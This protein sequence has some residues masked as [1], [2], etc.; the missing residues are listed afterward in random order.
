MPRQVFQV[1]VITKVKVVNDAWQYRVKWAGYDSSEDTWEPEKNLIGCQRLT[2][3]FWAHFM[4]DG[5]RR[6]PEGTVIH[7]TPE[8]IEREKEIF[9]AD[10]KKEKAAKMKKAAAAKSKKASASTTTKKS[11]SK[12]S[13]SSRAKGKQ[14][15]RPVVE[16]S[17]SSDEPLA[18]KPR[19]SISGDENRSASVSSVRSNPN[20]ASASTSKTKR[21]VSARRQASPVPVEDHL[22]LF[23]PFPSPSESAPPPPKPFQ[24][25]PTQPKPARPAA[26][27]VTTSTSALT[28]QPIPS[29][30]LPP[31]AS[32]APKHFPKLPKPGPVLNKPQTA[33]PL[34]IKLPASPP[35]Q[36][37][38]A[39]GSS[40]TT[41][42]RLAE[43]ALS[44]LPPK[45]SRQD[46]PKFKKTITTTPDTSTKT[47]ITEA[48]KAS[49]AAVSAL[50]RSS[51]SEAQDARVATPPVTQDVQPSF[52]RKSSSP[53]PRQ[54][55]ASVFLPAVAEP[56][57]SHSP[58]TSY[59]PETGDIVAS[60]IDCFDDPM[61]IDSSF[62][63]HVGTMSSVVESS[64]SADMLAAE[65]FLHGLMPPG[66]AAP[67]EPADAALTPTTFGPPAV[68]LGRGKLPPLPK[69]S[70]VYKWH[71][72]LYTSDGQTKTCDVSLVDVSEAPAEGCRF[73]PFLDNI[74]TIRSSTFYDLVDLD[75]FLLACDKPHQIGRLTG[76]E[77]ADLE[78]MNP[79]TEYMGRFKKAIIYP[80]ALDDEVMAYMVM[81]SPKTGSLSKR[82]RIPAN[83]LNHSASLI[84]ALVP[85]KDILRYHKDEWRHR[86]DNYPLRDYK[87]P[88]MDKTRL[89]RSLRSNPDFLL[90]LHALKF[91]QD[92]WDF[93]VKDRRDY[94]IWHEGGDGIGKNYGAQTHHLIKIL[95]EC[96]ARNKG[97]KADVRI[98]FVHVGALRTLPQ[99]IALAERR[100][101]RPE[102]NFFTY[103]SHESVEF[104]RWGVRH[105]YPLGGLV[106]FTPR[107]ILGDNDPLL[108]MKRIQHI[109]R[110]GHW[111][112]Y[113]LPSVVAYAAKLATAPDDP[114]MAFDEGTLRSSF[115]FDF[116]E[117]G[118][119]AMNEAP[120]S[121]LQLMLA[122]RGDLIADLL[123]QTDWEK[124]DY[125]VEAMKRFDAL[126]GPIPEQ[127]R[128]DAIK[129]EVVKSITA[130]QLQPGIMDNYR[131]FIII[132]APD[133]SGF[134]S[135][136]GLE[137]MTIDDFDFKDN[138]FPRQ[139]PNGAPVTPVI[140][141]FKPKNIRT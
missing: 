59:F 68:G 98:V 5:R 7:A 82:Y 119:V 37:S 79:L 104:D 89:D 97:Y 103:G 30:I 100:S 41:K 47:P 11:Q 76:Q 49:L 80:L 61:D 87:L 72:A 71:G 46:L 67:L 101:K 21:S 60:P 113:V 129:E 75:T 85:G 39:V 45:Q 84:V 56:S 23:T 58:V 44:L 20:A 22:A 13:S 83:M 107:A 105:I 114:L 62:N 6:H 4:C 48:A 42:Q 94:L 19:V 43:T 132:K 134:P 28:S 38:S 90:A 51:S 26:M 117:E 27:K 24:S 55:S 136:I 131:R 78:A 81:F 12:V 139:K 109:A 112:S 70:K 141:S 137:Y 35:K 10:E 111:A 127:A 18:Q 31:P 108:L 40:L 63:D 124:R 15:A 14:K 3:S 120:P 54:P 95:D 121:D 86:I 69:I 65:Q 77:A 135:D 17:S 116:I 133:E 9:W 140:E 16:T 53:A 73:K 66:L 125:L 25:E 122:Q 102:I 130:M 110:H 64:K 2:D 36:P 33:K 128:M 1:E 115:I 106:T 96:G 99:L 50:R 88:N 138:V 91:P 29:P 93:L 57:P 32:A 126:Y 8:W 52:H 34:T 123:A 92:V 118:Q 74:D